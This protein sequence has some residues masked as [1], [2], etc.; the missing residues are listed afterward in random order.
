MREP[1]DTPHLAPTVLAPTQTL[2]VWH[3]SRRIALSL[4]CLANPV[5]SLVLSQ[6]LAAGY[7]LSEETF[8]LY[9]ICGQPQPSE[10]LRLSFVKSHSGESIR[11]LRSHTPFFAQERLWESIPLDDIDC[12]SSLGRH[13]FDCPATGYSHDIHLSTVTAASTTKFTIRQDAGSHRLFLG[14][15]TLVA[16]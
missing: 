2:L 15:F 11:S 6:S 7:L 14:C 8:C 10:H 4:Q 9:G 13:S 5:S 16:T 12:C 1:S 3:V